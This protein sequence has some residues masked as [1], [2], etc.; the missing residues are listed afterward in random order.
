[1]TSKRPE[2]REH[3]LV[4]LARRQLAEGK[5]DR[6]DFLRNVTLLGVSAAPPTP[7]P[8]KSWARRSSR[9]PR[10]PRA[11]RSWAAPC[12]ARWPCRRWRTSRC[13]TGS[14]SRTARHIV[15]Y[16]TYTGPDNITRPYLAESWEPSDDLKTWTFRPR[17]GIKWSNGDEFNADD[18]VFNFKRWLTRNRIL[19][20]RPVQ[21]SGRGIRHRR[22]GCGRQA[23]DGTAGASRRSRRSMTTR[24][25]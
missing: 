19:E 6:R 13:S 11:T 4:D 22:E 1:M 20:H 10:R 7:W 15:E 25:S 9:R 21:R 3:P 5:S 16:L 8:A 24:S 23:E 17:K 18:V 12:G 14:R 2:V